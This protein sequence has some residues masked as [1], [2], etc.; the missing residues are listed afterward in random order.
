MN[1]LEIPF[2]ELTGACLNS[3]GLLQQPFAP[4]CQNHLGT[5]HAGVQFSLAEAASGLFLQ[6]HF[7]ELADGVVP[8]LREAHVKYRKSVNGDIVAHPAASEASIDRFLQQMTGKGRGSIEVDVVLQNTAGEIV[9]NGRF[10]WFIQRIEAGG[11]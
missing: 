9:C 2:V 10:Q 7:P 6:Q 5:M 3:E 11:A 4:A 1:I 8:V